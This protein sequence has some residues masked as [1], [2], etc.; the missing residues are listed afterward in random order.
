MALVQRRDGCVEIIDVGQ[1]V[2]DDYVPDLGFLNLVIGLTNPRYNEGYRYCSSYRE[3]FL[4]VPRFCSRC[5]LRL[6]KPRRE[7]QEYVIVWA[8]MFIVGYA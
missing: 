8:R 1:R 6:S 3:A 2:I 4:T 7:A 5:R